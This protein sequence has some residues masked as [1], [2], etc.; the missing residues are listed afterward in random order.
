MGGISEDLGSKELFPAG[1]IRRLHECSAPDQG[2]EG[3]L[4]GVFIGSCTNWSKYHWLKP[5]DKKLL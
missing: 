2:L 5:E 1:G 4:M 3:C